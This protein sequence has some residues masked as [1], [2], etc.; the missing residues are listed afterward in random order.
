VSCRG[1]GFTNPANFRF[2]G[3]CGQRLDEAEAERRQLTVMFFDLVGSTT[4]SAELDPEELRDLV[5]SYQVRCGDVVRRYGG[6]VAQFLGDGILVYFGYP[7][8]HSDDGCRAVSCALSILQAMEQLSRELSASKQPRLDLRVGMHTG[9]VV[10]GE[11][12]GGEHRENLAIGETPNVAARLQGLA[13]INQVVFSAE[14]YELLGDAFEVEC[15]GEHS[16]KGVPQPVP[17]YRALGWAD[18]PDQRSRTRAR[19]A[20]CPLIGRDKAMAELQESWRQAQAGR[21]HVVQLLGEQGIGKS[22][23]LQEFKDQAL[24][25]NILLLGCY[26]EPQYADVPWWGL[27]SLLERL[28][29][30]APGHLPAADKLLHLLHEPRYYPALRHLL[31]LEPHPEHRDPMLSPAAWRQFTFTALSG[32]FAHLSQAQP[33]LLVVDGGE[34]LDPSTLEWLQS[35]Q[36]AGTRGLI[37]V[38]GQTS[39]LPDARSVLLDRLDSDGAARF[40][41]ELTAPDTLPPALLQEVVERGDGVPLFLEELALLAKR[42]PGIV[43]PAKLRDFFTARLDGLGPAK[44]SAQ[45]ASVIGRRFSRRLLGVLRAAASESLEGEILELLDQGVVL[46]SSGRDELLFRHALMREACYESLLKATRQQQHTALADALQAHYGPWCRQNP[47]VIA[48]HLEHS[49]APEQA[50]PWYARA[51]GR[52]L[53][54]S[55]LQEATRIAQQSLSLLNRLPADH[56]YQQ[57]RLRFLTL[58]GTAWIGLRGY[59]APEVA[60]CYQTAHQLCE[61][62][63]DTLPL[64]PVLAGLWALYLVQGKLDE[65]DALCHRLS[66][67]SVAAEPLHRRLAYATGGQTQFF[68]GHLREARE[69]LLEAIALYTPGIEDGQSL[70]YLLTEPSIASASYLS[71]CELMLGDEVAARKWG[72]QALD[73][74]RALAHPH[75]LAHTLFFESW[76]RLNS[77]D[78]VSAEPVITELARLAEQQAFALWQAMAAA[79]SG[80][81]ALKR[82]DM[83]GATQLQAGLE[84]AERTGAKLGTTWWL[85]N[86]SMLLSA[87]GQVEMASAMLQS[88]RDSAEAAQERW[89]WPLLLQLS[90]QPEQARAYAEHQGTVSF[91][92]RFSSSAA[93]P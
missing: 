48:Y 69:K 7:E 28:L 14:T 87:S 34:A 41:A 20:L 61:Q 90:G 31:H 24:Q 27:T 4:L 80:H 29:R 32:F 39:V 91:L 37:V 86:L 68:R 89:M 5:R 43:L 35:V 82:G 74:A 57:Y 63:E 55:A 33:W 15:L 73:W 18:G 65:A 58:Q 3:Q 23:L 47:S 9:L 85:A 60:E 79:L 50:V 72:Q 16:L 38:A 56:P 45:L 42:R 26:P 71:W 70:A 93:T 92:L 8:A 77:G 17:V 19:R 66:A 78:L 22:R 2:C 11:L 40:V 67:L 51:L 36:L 49:A 84:A 64:F 54:V 30:K 81:L 21:G 25:S 12:G 1:C 46:S 53:A 52:C 75:T 62:I 83:R 6:H 88:A 76:L 44:R 59:A 13:G 10:V